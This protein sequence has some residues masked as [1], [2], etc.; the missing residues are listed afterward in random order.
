M[1]HDTQCTR[2]ENPV[3]RKSPARPPFALPRDEGLD[4]L[5]ADPHLG[6]TAKTIAT[7]LVKHWAWSKDHCWPS[8]RTIAG[9][10]GKSPGHVQRCMRELESAG[11]IARER[12][13]EVATGRRIWLAW[14]RTTLEGARP[15]AAPALD[16]PAAPARDERSVIV[17]D[18]REPGPLESEERSRPEQGPEPVPI[19]PPAEPAY[20][21]SPD[22]PVMPG[23]A[24]RLAA[25]PEAAREQVL[26]WL[27]TG[28][29]ILVAEARKRLAPPRPAV[30][31]PATLD[32]ALGRIREDPSFPHLAADW[33]AAA[34][35]DRK[36]YQGFLAR[37][38]EVWRGDRDPGE[39]VDAL[40]Q[41]T[42][43]AA[44]R[45]GAVFMHVLRR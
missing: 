45:P 20:S 3:K 18:G 35:D 17:K 14:R 19:A 10:V 5:L 4:R 30:S 2:F 40:R 41:A 42:G 34:L 33:L 24:E 15:D 6:S 23:Q 9:K 16:P 12:T 1:T 22:A 13:D 21:P 44:K 29:P 32:E 28:D 39:L 11:Y 26:T 7:A 27:A 31:R 37:C 36:S 38:T 25:M 8:D 43:P